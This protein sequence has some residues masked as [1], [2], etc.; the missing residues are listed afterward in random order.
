MTSSNYRANS[1]ST[2]RT[3]RSPFVP[4]FSRSQAK[5]RYH[6][7]A[8]TY[9]ACSQHAAIASRLARIEATACLHKK[10]AV[11]LF[12]NAKV[13]TPRPSTTSTR[14]QGPKVESLGG[15]EACQK[16]YWQ[17]F[18]R[19]RAGQILRSSTFGD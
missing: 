12:A 5:H 11:A 2:T 6:F 17:N 7:A 18:R 9:D 10:Q 8:C 1:I 14:P 19:P 13:S 15:F 16:L 4:S 3:N